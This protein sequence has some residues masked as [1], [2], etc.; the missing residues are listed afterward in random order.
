MFNIDYL[1]IKPSET[2]IKKTFTINNDSY[3][4]LFTHNARFDFYSVIIM[5]L[6][7][8]VLYSNKITYG[9]TLNDFEIPGLEL[10]YKI[11]PFDIDDFFTEDPLPASARVVNSSTLDNTVRLYFN[12]QI[13]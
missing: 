10:D 1:P 3:V 6:E 7:E 2:P 9:Q 13:I 11:L 4:F 5:D 8:N 12:G